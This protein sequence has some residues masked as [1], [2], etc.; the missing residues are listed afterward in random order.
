MMLWIWTRTSTEWFVMRTYSELIQL[1]THRER[2]RYLALQGEVCGETFGSNRWINQ[3]FYTSRA[4]RQIRHDV[5]A[6][7]LGCDL[8]IEGFEIHD[9]PIIHHMNPLVLEDIMYGTPNALDME[10][11][12][13]VTHDTHNAIHYG[14]ESQLRQPFVPRTPGDTRLWHPLPRPGRT[15]T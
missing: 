5:I 3:R 8:A 12:I 4:W 9:R 13:L 14:D 7:D 2:F 1:P 6:R 10:F 15:R 11:L